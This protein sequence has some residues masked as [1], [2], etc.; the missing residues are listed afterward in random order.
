MNPIRFSLRPFHAEGEG[1]GISITGAIARRAG[2]LSVFFA[3]RGDL[4]ALAIPA[5]ASSP[6]RKD[7]LWEETCFELF[8]GAKGSE[9]YW[10]FNLSPAGH[11]NVYRF[12]DYREGMTREP[13]FARLPF[14]VRKGTAALELRLEV[15]IGKIVP[16]GAAFEVGVSAVAK[17][18]T[19]KATH[20]ALAHP[21]PRP[22]FHRR[23]GFALTV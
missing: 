20:W 3:L 5:A 6:V 1:A 11:W 4:R 16:A 15:D 13:A 18:L 14:V 8:F 23:D 10:E 12:S 19:G 21:G 17:T 9:R 7:R 2:I 22:D